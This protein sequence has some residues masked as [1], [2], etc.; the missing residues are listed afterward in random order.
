MK[1]S[2]L[3]AFVIASVI[4]C[5]MGVHYSYYLLFGPDESVLNDYLEKQ[6]KDAENLDELV[7][8][9]EESLQLVATRE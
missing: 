6:I 7:A 8:R 9:Y 1:G 5:F 2:S 3:A 4:L